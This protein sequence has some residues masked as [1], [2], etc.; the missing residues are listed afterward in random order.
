MRGSGVGEGEEGGGE[1]NGGK[2][3]WKKGGTG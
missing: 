3:L 2:E 1:G